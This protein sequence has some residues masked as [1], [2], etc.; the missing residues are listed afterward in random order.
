MASGRQT[1][2]VVKLEESN[3]IAAILAALARPDDYEVA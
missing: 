1:H 3:A 2:A